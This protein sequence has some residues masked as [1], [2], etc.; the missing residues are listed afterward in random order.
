MEQ[1]LHTLEYNP[2]EEELRE[3]VEKGRKYKIAAEVWRN[4]L[5]ER[6]EEIT[7]D[8]EDGHYDESMV[9]ELRVMKRFRNLCEAMITVGEI[10]EE[11]LREYGE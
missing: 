8:F 2:D 7:K 10:A 6:R 4:F 3:A 1:E 11:D 5:D 9:A